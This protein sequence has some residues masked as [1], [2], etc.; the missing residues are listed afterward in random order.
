M[1]KIENTSA[2]STRSS[3]PKILILGIPCLLFIIVSYLLWKDLGE[4]LGGTN[5][6]PA[7]AM[8]QRIK[9]HVRRRPLERF[10]WYPAHNNR[11]ISVNDSV[12]TDQDSSIVLVFE[13][14][15]EI[16]IGETS[17]VTIQKRFNQVSISMG[18]GR[19]KFKSK[20]NSTNAPLL[21]SKNQVISI[22]NGASEG[23]ID[24][25]DSLLQVSLK[26]GSVSLTEGKKTQSLKVNQTLQ[27]AEDGSKQVI[28][29]QL[30]LLKPLSDENFLIRE[31]QTQLKSIEF[32]WNLDQGSE[33][34]NLPLNLEI[35][36]SSTF[37]S[38]W[39]SIVAPNPFMSVSMPAGTYFWRSLKNIN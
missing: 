13:G 32:A 33:K 29:S 23:V 10:R 3:S 16:E 25:K 18:T 8:T 1:K 17:L 6:S 22:A 36:P 4:D 24:M 31:D 2:N 28:Q 5:N 34:K 14:G 27:I 15:T 38:I 26:N 20:S 11:P 39:Q 35:S 9:G 21:M 19:V 30:R 12:V 37:N 7:V